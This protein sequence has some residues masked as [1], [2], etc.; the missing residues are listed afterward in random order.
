MNNDFKLNNNS[1]KS[2]ENLNADS[3][4]SEVILHENFDNSI[5]ST[6]L[7]EPEDQ[8]LKKSKQFDGLFP[9]EEELINQIERGE[10]PYLVHIAQAVER[11]TKLIE[12]DPTTYTEKHHVVPIHDGGTDEESNKVDLTFNDHTIAHY[13]RWFMF[14]SE[15]DRI[16]WQT[17][18]GQ[19]Q[20]V[21]RA[22]ARYG[23]QKGGPIAQVQHKERG[24]GWFNSEVQRLR[25]KKGASVNRK[26]GTGAFDPI[27]LQ[28]ANAE[29][30]LKKA[31]NPAKYANQNKKN[32]A[33]GRQTQKEKGVNIGDPLS[34]RRKSLMHHGILLNGVRY[35][36]DTEQRT[37]VCETTF[38]YYLQKT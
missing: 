25:G 14:G 22:V 20:D 31:K 9:L 4:T 32:L 1:F 34:Q 18:S 26:Q 28:K 24:V 23:G 11:A 36:C 2:D 35:Y 29:L 6:D 38:E 7:T 8:P 33:Q 5:T 27:N 15:G 17:M 16:A 21:R 19:S 3:A 12:Q 30:A 13:I 10:D 37:Y